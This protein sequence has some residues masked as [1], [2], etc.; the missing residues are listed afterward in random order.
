[1]SGF[2]GSGTLLM[3]RLDI[4]GAQFTEVGNATKFEIHTPTEFRRRASRMKAS[5]GQ[6]LDTVALPQDAS[7]GFTLDDVNPENL[8][9]ALLG[10]P[11]TYTQTAATDLS[12]TVTAVS[13]A[14]HD[15]GKV[16]LA[17]V[18][19]EQGATTYTAGTDYEV[20][21]EIGMLKVLA[22]GSITP[23][24]ELS[25]RYDCAEVSGHAVKGATR[26]TVSVALILD[27]RNH[28]DGSSCRVDVYRAR[29]TPASAVN[30]L[31]QEFTS[32]DFDGSLEKPADKDHPFAV[33]TADL[34]A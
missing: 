34:A 8:A 19:V 26:P 2:L 7:L 23:A 11:E 6:T 20:N 30:F 32:V 15:L 31:S 9:L 17:N 33:L 4:P 22:G 29:I 14:W 12:E 24:A 13:G 5:Y 18:V 21:A 16:K 28:V 10:V 1:M 25:V 27:G 3:K